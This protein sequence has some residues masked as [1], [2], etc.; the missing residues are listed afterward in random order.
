MIKEKILVI[1]M[2]LSIY[3]H[4]ATKFNFSKQLVVIYKILDPLSVIV[5]KPEKMIVKKGNQVFRYSEVTSSHTPLKI[6]IEAPYNVRDEIL[7][8][9]YGTATL[10]LRNNGEFEL[11][12]IDPKESDNLQSIGGRG[13]F[14]EVGIDSHKMTLSLYAPTIPNKYQASTTVD[15]IFNERKDNMTMGTY[16]GVLI[17]DVTYGD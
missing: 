5:D 6:T 4:T 17:L 9:I 12:N 3:S 2:L 15:A 7:D 1:F 10:E 13:F 8:K 16:R 11:I 14:P